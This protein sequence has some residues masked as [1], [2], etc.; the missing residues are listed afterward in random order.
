MATINAQNPTILDVVKR[1]NPDGAIA[2]I[3]EM[4]TQRNGLL[5]Y[6]GWQEGNLTSG[7]RIT[8]RTGLPSIGWRRLNEGV[9]P[10]KSRTDQY[11]ESC[12]RLEGLSV[13]DCGVAELNGNEAAYRASESAAFMQSF[14]NEVETGMIYHSTKTA[15]EKFMG[16]SARFDATANPGGSQIIKFDGGALGSDQS[17]MWLVKTGPKAVYGI[18]PKGSMGGLQYKD[19]GMQLWDDGTG[20][21]FRAYVMNWVWQV[22]LAVEDWRCVSRIANIDNTNLAATG[23]L[24]IQNAIRAY[25]KIFDPNDGVGRLVWLCN[26][27]IATYLHLQAVDAVKNATLRIDEVAGGPVTK[28]LGIPVVET[29]ALL[30]TEAVIT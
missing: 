9:T 25:H 26:R 16:L 5:K 10:S 30:D 18:Y 20:K 4:L 22:G 24:L 28:L 11:D 23:N 2:S 17:S 12:G 29:D 14:N 3:I 13:V 15:P 27:N 6:L 21:K 8:S 7:H 19:M 1:S